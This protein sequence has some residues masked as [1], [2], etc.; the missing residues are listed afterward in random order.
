VEPYILPIYTYA[1]DVCEIP[2]EQALP[3]ARYDEPQ[4]CPSCGAIARK[5]V[6][7]VSFNLAGD[8]WASK[9]GRVAAQMAEKNRRLAAKQEERRRDAPGVKLAPNVGGERV[10]S[11]SDAKKLAESQGKNGASYDKLVAAEK[12]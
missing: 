8:G 12:K 9:N 1:C 11:W 5:T 6:A 4:A 10:D 3:L 7:M 2:F